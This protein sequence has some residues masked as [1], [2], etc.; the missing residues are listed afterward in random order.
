MQK[1]CPNVC[2]VWLR[3]WTYFVAVISG[4]GHVFISRCGFRVGSLS[5]RAAVDLMIPSSSISSP[6]VSL[7][8]YISK[9]R[10]YFL[11]LTA[12][13]FLGALCLSEQQSAPSNCEPV[14]LPEPSLHPPRGDGPFLAEATGHCWA[15]GHYWTGKGPCFWPT[16]HLALTPPIIDGQRGSF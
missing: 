3:V 11:N 14:T 6:P 9:V 8:T 2:W 4:H 16:P 7:A 5:G 10:F 12:R 13:L 15:V 1:G